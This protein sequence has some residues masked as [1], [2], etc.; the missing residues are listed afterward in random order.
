MKSSLF[1][2]ETDYPK[3]VKLGDQSAIVAARSEK[4]GSNRLFIWIKSDQSLTTGVEKARRTVM[5][6]LAYTV[7]GMAA[8][9]AIQVVMKIRESEGLHQGLQYVLLVMRWITTVIQLI[10]RAL[11]VG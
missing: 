6:V 8:A 1:H 5:A 3:T 10:S 9:F 11:T 2:L 7:Y 4:H